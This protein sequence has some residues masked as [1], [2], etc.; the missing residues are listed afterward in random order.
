MSFDFDRFLHLTFTQ[1]HGIQPT[2]A[3]T[4]FVLTLG[5]AAASYISNT[6]S[7]QVVLV[8][9]WATVRCLLWRRRSCQTGVQ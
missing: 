1:A 7:A 2:A 8:L 4:V 6:T 3:P 9:L 5:L